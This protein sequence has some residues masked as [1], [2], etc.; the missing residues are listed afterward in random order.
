MLRGKCKLT[1]KH[2]TFVKSH[3]IPD[4]LTRLTVR[5]S[6]RI[7]GGEGTRPKRRFS[8][9]YDPELV[10]QEGEDILQEYDTW[11]IEELRRL[12]LIWSSW[13]PMVSLS[14]PDWTQAGT[15]GL[16][17]RRLTCS[18]PA[19]A[20]LF[21]LSL[22]WRA[23][24]TS[25]VEF[26]GVQLD[27]RELERLRSLLRNRDPGPLD[28]YPT[29]LL[30]ITS[31]GPTHN[32]APIAQNETADLG[33]GTSWR[34][35][36][37]GFYFDGLIAHMHRP[38]SSVIPGVYGDLR[39]FVVGSGPTLIVQTQPLEGSFEITN[40]EKAVVESAL[41]WPMDTEQL[42]GIPA[43]QREYA[44]RK[45]SAIYGHGLPWTSRKDQKE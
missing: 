37:F 34:Q 22:L 43:S 42:T 40:L 30:Q 31:Q 10:T 14:T 36:A 20:R 29:T 41:Q 13:G 23:A 7:E 24:A 28:F 38:L 6:L 25:R 5:G 44:L 9:W 19:K 12:K 27:S 33:G 35:F 4:A 32:L 45:Y 3:L 39:P 15:T 8:S 17:L 11:A 16:G 2:G 18:D 26:R 1:H 21:F